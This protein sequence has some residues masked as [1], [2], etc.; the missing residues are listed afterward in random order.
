VKELVAM[1]ARIGRALA[2]GMVPRELR[3]ARKA[4][5]L[6]QFAGVEGRKRGDG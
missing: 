2:R 6:S 1:L 5:L 4:A 3:Q